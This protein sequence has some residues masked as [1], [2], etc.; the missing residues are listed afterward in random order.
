[1]AMWRQ[2]PVLPLI[3]PRL[4]DYDPQEWPSVQAWS[5]ARFAWLLEHPERTIDGTDC[6]DAIYEL[7]AY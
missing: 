1:M 7:E 5:D 2:Q 4:R 6:V 3:P